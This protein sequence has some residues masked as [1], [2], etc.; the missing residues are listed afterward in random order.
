MFYNQPDD[1]RDNQFM[2]RADYNFG[3]HRVVCE[4]FLFPLREDPVSGAQTII[5]AKQ[6]LNLFDQNISAAD[7]YAITPAVLNSFVFSFDRYFTTVV[8]GAPFS[9]ASLGI[10]IAS[11]TPPSCL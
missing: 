7:T 10:P 11:T 5:T 9:F 2:T 3:K 8:S 6:G 1:E 4:V